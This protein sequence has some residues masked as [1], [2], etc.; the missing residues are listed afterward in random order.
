MYTLYNQ[1]PPKLQS[2]SSNPH[3]VKLMHGSGFGGN[4]STDTKLLDFNLMVDEEEEN[5]DFESKDIHIEPKVDHFNLWEW[6]VDQTK[7]DVNWD[8]GATDN[9]TGDR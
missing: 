3:S 2:R 4:N 8:S 5:Y 9:V 6:S 7:K 1:N